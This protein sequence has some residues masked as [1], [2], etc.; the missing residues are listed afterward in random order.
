MSTAS[1]PIGPWLTS[2]IASP[3]VDVVEKMYVEWLDHRVVHRGVVGEALARSWGAPKIAGAKMALLEPDSGKQVYLRIIESPA[4]DGFRPLTTFGWAAS[5]LV[6][7]N[8]DALQ[9]RMKRSPFRIIGPAAD[10]EMLK[11]IRAMQVV[12]AANEVFYLTMFKK[13]IDGFDLP[14]AHSFVD[15][16][17]IAVLAS[18]RPE[19][20]QG[21]YKQ[22]FGITPG[23]VADI[24]LTLLDD[25]FGVPPRSGDYRLT[26]V[27]L[28]GRSLVE[29][30]GYPR[31]ARPRPRVDGHLPPGNA[32]M[33]VLVDSLDGLKVKF[34]REPLLLS[35]PPYYGRRAAT[36]LGAVGELI[37]LVEREAA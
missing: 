32:L 20:V 4:P 31:E 12:G 29:V 17:F 14:T 5:E 1:P 6:V 3:D 9:E 35:E 36:T 23:D 34:F 13:N 18:D 30:D 10:L 26:V 27:A 11:D 28:R 2:T 33:S 22:H 7:Q 21:W 25:A 37:E 15:R 8:T 19:K 24:K 16:M